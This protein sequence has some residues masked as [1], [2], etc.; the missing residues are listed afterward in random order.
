MLLL[1]YPT[2]QLFLMI[3]IKFIRLS[4]NHIFIYEYEQ[5]GF[6]PGLLQ[7]FNLVLN[8]YIFNPL[9]DCCQID[10]IYMEF[11]KALDR[12]DHSRLVKILDFL[13]IDSL[14]S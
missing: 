13:S 6:R 8:S 4:L 1:F 5:H 11:S 10:V 2:Y 12:I 14:F 7:F 3:E 9:R